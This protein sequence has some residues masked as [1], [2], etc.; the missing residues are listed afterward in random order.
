MPWKNAELKSNSFN[1]SSSSSFINFPAKKDTEN[2][3]LSNPQCLEGRASVRKREGKQ[4]A[5]PRKI[6]HKWHTYNRCFLPFQPSFFLEN[7]IFLPQE[8]EANLIEVHFDS[9]SNI[10]RRDKPEL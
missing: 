10:S 4:S 8:L 7:H 5:L 9:I 6:L 1:F 2:G 3:F